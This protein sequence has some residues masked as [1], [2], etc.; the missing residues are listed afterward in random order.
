[1]E[2]NGTI[3]DSLSWLLFKTRIWLWGYEQTHKFYRMKYCHKGYHKLR[4]ESI[5]IQRDG[6]H[7]GV[8]Y[9]K[10]LHCNYMFFATMRDKN[11]YLK[12]QEL[13]KERFSALYENLSGTKTEELLKRRVGFHGRV[14][15]VSNNKK[16]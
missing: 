7:Y 8:E 14:S 13:T 12:I 11:K 1:M 6:K 4:K 9:I 2:G 16:C 5:A 15:S 3:M 10:C